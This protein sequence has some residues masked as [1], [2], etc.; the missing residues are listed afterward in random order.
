M[1]KLLFS[2]K[3]KLADLISVNHSLILMLPRFGIPLGFGDKSVK[4]ICLMNDV[5]ADFFLLVCN[6][7]AFNSYLPK[8]KMIESTDMRLLVPYLLASHRVGR[9][10]V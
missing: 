1:E 2:E 6:V 4:E 9:A 5:S 3:M 10:H 8:R 7:Y